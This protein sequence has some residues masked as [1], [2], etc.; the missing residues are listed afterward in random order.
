MGTRCGDIDPGVIIYLIRE[1]GLSACDLESILY[2]K[3]GLLGL[4][5][6]THNVKLLEESQDKKAQ[7]ALAFFCLKV[8]QYVGMMAVGLGGMDAIVFT[9]GI[10]ENSAF[11]RDKVLHHLR[12]LQPFEVRMIPTDE[13]KIMA[14]HTRVLLDNK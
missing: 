12:F 6:L 11:V 5:S 8:A 9:G 7:F 1:L 4:S 14:M 10:G 13:E 2:E 3:S